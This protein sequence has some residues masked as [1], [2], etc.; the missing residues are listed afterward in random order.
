MS[1]LPSNASPTS[2]KT[3]SICSSLADVELRHE[4]ALNR[5]GEV[6]NVLLDPLALE[7]EGQRGAAVGERLAIAQAIDRLFATPRMS[8]FFPSNMRR[9]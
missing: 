8:A 7:R 4:R 2:R 5:L 9:L 1:S 6:A 3:R